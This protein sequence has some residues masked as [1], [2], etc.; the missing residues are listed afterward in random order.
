MSG[1]RVGVV[2]NEGLASAVEAAGGAPVG[3]VEAF[4]SVRFVVAA[5]DSVVTDLARRSVTVPVLAVAAEAGL[6]AVPFDRLGTAIRR[7]LDG[8]PPTRRHPIVEATGAFDPVRS[9]FDVTLVAAEP[10]R[11][12]EFAVHSGGGTVST[13]RADG[14]AVSTPA[15]SGGYNR[16]AGGPVVAPETGVASVVPI[17]PF[18]TAADHWIVPIDSV[19]LSVER[20][21]TPVELL[22]DGRRELTVEASGAVTLSR[23]GSLETY[24]LPESPDPF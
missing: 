3:D 17:A 23:A 5:G 18:A 1:Q 6:G 2:G 24:V 19:R 21:E 22:A 15:G 16:S 20:D 14:V 7:V 8:D 10:A 9:I 4:D 12:S 11:I 13:F